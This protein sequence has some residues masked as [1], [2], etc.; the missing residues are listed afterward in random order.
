M[1]RPCWI[2]IPRAPPTIPLTSQP[3]L[4]T[5]AQVLGLRERMAVV[6]RLGEKRLLLKVGDELERRRVATAT[7]G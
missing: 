6:M 4:R 1:R 5:P 2:P 7:A 3:R